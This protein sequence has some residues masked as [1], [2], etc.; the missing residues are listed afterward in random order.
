MAT[1]QRLQALNAQGELRNYRYLLLSAHGYLS[2]EQPA[3]SSIVLGLQQRTAEADGYVT[4]AEWPGYD[5]RSE[6]A[7]LSACDSGVG[8]VV[9]GE[10]VMG[11]PFAMFVAGNVNTVL[12]LWPV[13]DR[14]AAD[15]VAAFFEKVR[16]GQNATQA[17]AATKREFSRH[18][19]WSHPSYWAPF[20]L[21]GA[22]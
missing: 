14:A 16:A 12:S 20:I 22:G 19:R 1:E 15:F 9:S 21:V 11:L 8:K 17:L 5:L 6:L 3:L 18:R 2:P 7:V 4:A 13:E 10:G